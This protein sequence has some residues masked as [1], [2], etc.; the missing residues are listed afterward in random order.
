MIQ[1]NARKIKVK[2][3]LNYKRQKHK[4]DCDDSDCKHKRLTQKE[5]TLLRIKQGKRKKLV[6]SIL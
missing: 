1:H 3:L 2:G 4:I 6:S 5:R